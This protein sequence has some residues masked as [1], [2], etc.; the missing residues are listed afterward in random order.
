[1]PTL[2]I[3]MSQEERARFVAGFEADPAFWDK[4][5]D[6]DKRSWYPG[7]R[8]YKDNDGLL[9]FRNANFMP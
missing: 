3:A 8:F 5:K 2:Q 9:Y 4:G 6:S 7:N 1:P